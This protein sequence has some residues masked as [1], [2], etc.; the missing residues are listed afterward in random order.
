MNTIDSDDELN[1]SNK[2]VKKRSN[3]I[4]SE[5]EN[6]K[7]DNFDEKCHM[8]NLG[9]LQLEGDNVILGN[10]TKK[11]NK[12]LTEIFNKIKLNLYDKTVTKFAINALLV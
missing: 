6:E 10:K 8:Y 11:E 9:D 1:I 4:E 2:I 3:S 5:L 12:E 7:I